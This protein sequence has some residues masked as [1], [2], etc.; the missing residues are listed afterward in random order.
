[1]LVNNDKIQEHRNLLKNM[2]NNKSTY[3]NVFTN[4]SDYTGID[5]SYKQIIKENYNTYKS[6]YEIINQSKS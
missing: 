4:P 6:F 2:L 5:N 1:M 3:A